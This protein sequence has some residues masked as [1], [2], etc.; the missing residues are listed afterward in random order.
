M[1]LDRNKP[2]Q[3]RDGRKVTIY[4]WNA[5]S[6]TYPI[7]GYADGFAGPSSWCAT[8]A[9]HTEGA[10]YQFDLINVPEQ[11]K[12]HKVKVAFLDYGGAPHPAPHRD[13]PFEYVGKLIAIKEI[14]FT[15]GEG[16]DK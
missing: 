3:T 7:H 11:P 16:L 10:I 14:E 1:S 2:V 5:P 4:T 8:G 9:Y 15:E 12:K 13:P 6:S